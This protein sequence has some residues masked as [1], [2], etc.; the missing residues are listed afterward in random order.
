M[1]KLLN[2]ELTATQREAL[3]RLDLSQLA[4]LRDRI[5]RERAWSP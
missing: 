5:E 1:C 3:Q 4:S 2:I